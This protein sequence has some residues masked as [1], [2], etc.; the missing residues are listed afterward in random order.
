M[1]TVALPL[2]AGAMTIEASFLKSRIVLTSGFVRVLVGHLE[3]DDEAKSSI[4]QRVTNPLYTASIAVI[5]RKNM[6][7]KLRNVY[8]HGCTST[9]PR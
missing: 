8:I 5:A 2:S 4:R 7:E 9:K 6:L 3:A 1:T